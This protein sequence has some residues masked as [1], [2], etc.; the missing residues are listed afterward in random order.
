MS[1]EN[2][3]SAIQDILKFATN[4]DYRMHIFVSDINE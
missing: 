3:L 4:H 2:K 1:Y